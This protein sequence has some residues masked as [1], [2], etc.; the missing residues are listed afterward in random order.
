MMSPFTWLGGSNR[1]REKPGQGVVTLHHDHATRMDV[2][3][4]YRCL[5]LRSAVFNGD[6]QCTEPDLDGRELEP[7]TVLVWAAIDG[8]PVGTLRILDDDDHI[9]IG[10]VVVDADHRGLHIGRRMM[11]L[12]LDL[13]RADGRQITLHAQ[14]HLESWYGDCGFVVTGPHF[15]EAG[16]DHVPMTLRR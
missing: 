12:A 7:T 3:T 5:W 16:I 15:D 10:R 11:G 2:A 6:Q 13:V 4:L 14:S 1:I 8:H 9:T